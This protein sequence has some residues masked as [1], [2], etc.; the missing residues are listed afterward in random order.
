MKVKTSSLIKIAVYFVLLLDS[1]FWLMKVVGRKFQIMVL[2]SFLLL[3]IIVF[4]P[5]KKHIRGKISA[6]NKY[7]AVLLAMIIVHAIYAKFH[8]SVPMDTFINSA[9]YYLIFFLSY[10]LICAFSIDNGTYKFWRFINVFSVIWYTWLILQ[11]IVYRYSGTI[12]SP[13]LKEAGLLINNIRN[14]NLRLEM[15]VLGHIAIIYNFDQFYNQEDSKHR[16][17]SFLMAIYGIITMFT[18]EQTRG[19]MIAILICIIV[20]LACYN[21]K[22]K[23]FLFTLMIII[24]GAILLYRTQYVSSLINSFFEGDN[25][26]GYY[27]LSGMQVF[28]NQFLRNPLWGYGFQ[29]TG[30]Y[31]ISGLGVRQFNDNGIVGILGQIG[32][33]GIIIYG[34]MLI[35]FGRIV[36]RMFKERD[37]KRGTFLLSLYVYL[38]V[39]S[40]SLICYWNSTCLLCA[41]SWAVFE[42]EYNEH[43]KVRGDLKKV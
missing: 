4:T 2:I 21:R 23:K 35:R 14:G 42:Y 41:I 19:Y 33:W 36:I 30:D 1:N 29:S 34:L 27:R 12:I 43:L 28:W 32:I 6:L 8:N 20:L 26:T 3:G 13:Y 39:T 15:R 10:S 16:T 37:F 9:C 5:I 18:V 40:V 22:S 11:F 17:K 25:A 24:V 7:A 31:I 38:L